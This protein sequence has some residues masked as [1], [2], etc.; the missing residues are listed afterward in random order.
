MV[1]FKTHLAIGFLIGLLLFKFLKVNPLFFI[2]LVTIFS[3]LP[4]IDHPRSKYGRKLWFFSIPISWVFK[5]RGF[6]HSVFPAV[7]GFFILSYFKFYLIAWALLIGYLAHLV[8]D[9]LTVQ[10]INF[11]HP[12][13]T[14]EIH[15]PIHTGKFLESILFYFVIILNVYYLLKIFNIL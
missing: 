11:L 14:F 2:P 8:G 6:F 12:F 15:G 9:A 3:A 1:M 7:I 4:D 5:H 13:S 10:G